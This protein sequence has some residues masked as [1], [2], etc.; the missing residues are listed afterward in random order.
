VSRQEDA[1]DFHAQ[2]GPASPMQVRSVGHA[3]DADAAGKHNSS[4]F[5]SFA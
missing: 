5:Q 4:R 2:H 3:V 1:A